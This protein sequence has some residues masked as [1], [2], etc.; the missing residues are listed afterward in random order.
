MSHKN[1]IKEEIE[2]KN[3]VPDMYHVILL[4][5]DITTMDFVVFILEKI[6]E[7]AHSEAVN[8]ML[9]VH[10]QGEGVAG[11]YVKEIAETKASQVMNM[12]QQNGFPLKCK[13]EEA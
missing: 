11:T 13:V 1:D 4:N 5:D 7:K 10:E 3:L 9:M 2:I 12:A 8:I 6:F